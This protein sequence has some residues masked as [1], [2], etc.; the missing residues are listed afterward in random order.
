MFLVE[1][2]PTLKNGNPFENSSLLLLDTIRYNIKEK[3]NNSN[4]F[5]IT[6]LIE[7]KSSISIVIKSG[8]RQHHPFA[9]LL[10]T[11]ILLS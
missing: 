4:T 9:L 5:S 2:V 11:I 6:Y 7:I 8:Q 1:R 10:K 3:P